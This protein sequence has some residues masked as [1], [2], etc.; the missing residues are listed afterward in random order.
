MA[1][2]TVQ[3]NWTKS[4]DAVDGYNVYE[5]TAPGNESS[6]PLNGTTLVVAN[7]YTVTVPS[8]GVYSFVITSVEN[9]AESVKS[10]EVVATVR[11]F[12]PSAVVLGTIS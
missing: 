9:G 10:N 4:T 1:T 11:P 2:H 5:G 8:P 6:T 12:P 3:I 7:T